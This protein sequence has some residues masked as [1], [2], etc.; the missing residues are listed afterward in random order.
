MKASTA[1]IAV[2]RRPDRAGCRLPFRR[3]PARRR[4]TNSLNG[5]LSVCMGVTSNQAARCRFGYPPQRS[6][7][8]LAGTFKSTSGRPAMAPNRSQE[9]FGNG[10]VECIAVADHADLRP[11]RQGLFFQG[12]DA[13]GCLQG[14]VSRPDG[15]RVG[16][17]RPGAFPSGLTLQVG[18]SLPHGRGDRQGLA[19]VAFGVDRVR[20]CRRRMA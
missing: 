14:H 19:L 11:L 2:D 3:R 12:T 17:N 8:A 20:N 13:P 10:D 15:D 5:S 1:S 9:A 16:G 4:G 18:E 7:K 6:G